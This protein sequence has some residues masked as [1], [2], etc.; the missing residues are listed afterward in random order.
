MNLLPCS[1]LLPSS[2]WVR[3][4]Q[5]FDKSDAHW[6][7]LFAKLQQPARGCTPSSCND[8]SGGVTMDALV[9]STD[10]NAPL[11]AIQKVAIVLPHGSKL[12]CLGS[13]LKSDLACPERLAID[14]ADGAD[15]SSSLLTAPSPPMLEAAPSTA[16]EQRVAAVDFAGF[17]VN[18]SPLDSK[19]IL[20]ALDKLYAEQNAKWDRRFADLDTA[21]DQRLAP[22]NRARAMGEQRDATVALGVSTLEEY[23]AAQPCVALS[24]RA[25]CPHPEER[26]LEL[27]ASDTAFGSVLSGTADEAA[28]TDQWFVDA[29]NA[30]TPHPI[31]RGSDVFGLDP[32]P[33]HIS[34]SVTPAPATPSPPPPVTPID[35]P[36]HSNLCSAVSASGSAYGNTEFFSVWEHL[37]AASLQA[38]VRAYTSDAGSGNFAVDLRSGCRIML[39][40]GSYPC[41]FGVEHLSTGDVHRVERDALET[42]N[43]G[44][45]RAVLDS[46]TS[47]LPTL[48]QAS[49][50]ST[51]NMELALGA[52][53]TAATPSDFSI[54]PVNHDAPANRS[55]KCLGGAVDV[56][57]PAAAS[58]VAMAPVIISTRAADTPT[59]IDVVCSI[60]TFDVDSGG[61]VSASLIIAGMPEVLPVSVKF[62][63]GSCSN[64][65][66]ISLNFVLAT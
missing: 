63:M 18:I 56:V 36:G 21:W 60:V 54:A 16:R 25:A 40:V 58:A 43:R 55:T 6:D 19:L 53:G 65:E 61:D 10:P 66:V 64:V 14:A 44:W 4:I 31:E 42:E 13:V 35:S 59:A 50:T 37:L 49:S 12:S 45:I 62:W 48:L 5:R 17:L 20:D 22:R 51:I 38:N 24:V 3:S 11:D 9:I 47:S 1:L 39:P 29:L 2:S 46:T 28:S 27:S 33:P 34:A 32:M 57:A 41:W 30:P 26:V 8:D 15:P 7:Q 52:T 23:S